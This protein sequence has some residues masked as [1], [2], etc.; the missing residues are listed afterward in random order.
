[1]RGSV[2]V[3]AEEKTEEEKKEDPVAMDVGETEKA[4]PTTLE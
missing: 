4:D 1:M 2:A 3:V